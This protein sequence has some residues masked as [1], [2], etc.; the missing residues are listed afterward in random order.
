MIWP[1]DLGAH[2]LPL[3][4]FGVGTPSCVSHAAMLAADWLAMQRANICGTYSRPILVGTSARWYF[5][6]VLMYPNGLR[7]T[8]APLARLR[9]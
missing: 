2:T 9:L 7:L 6:P 4:L 8:S 1:T 3:F 5:G